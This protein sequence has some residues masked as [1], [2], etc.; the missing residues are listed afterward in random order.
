MFVNESWLAIQSH[1]NVAITDTS[2]G[3]IEIALDEL[4]LHIEGHE[5]SS[6]IVAYVNLNALDAWEDYFD[7]DDLQLLLLQLLKTNDELLKNGLTQ[8]CLAKDKEDDKRLNITLIVTCN[9]L[10]CDNAN[11]VVNAITNLI[12]QASEFKR[13][14]Q[15]K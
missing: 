3:H 6:T 5:V 2:S 11:D 1:F 15:L 4:V 14:N 13:E 7:E 10:V 12:E 9:D 8:F